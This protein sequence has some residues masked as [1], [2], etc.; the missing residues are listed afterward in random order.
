MRWKL[1]PLAAFPLF[2]A[3]LVV[4]AVALA[5]PVAA[6]P[7]RRPYLFKD[8]RGELAQ[9]RARGETEVVV[10]VASMPQRNARVAAAIERMGGRIGFRFDEVDYVRAWV[11]LEGAEQLAD[12]PDVHSIDISITNRPRSFGLA[13]G[14][15]DGTLP[16]LPGEGGPGDGGPGNAGAAAAGLT[17]V[18]SHGGRAEA[19]A[20]DTEA[21]DTVWPPRLTDR[22][23]A[24][25]Y[26]PLGDLRALDF[27]DANP[28]FDGRG[29]TIGQIDMF[30]DMLLPELQTA[31]ALDG[32]PVPKIEIYRNV[33]DPEIEDDGRW[34][35]MDDQVE[36]S[37]GAFV[38]RDS[39]YVAPR[40]GIFRI[41]MFDESRADSAG[42]Y[43]SQGLDLDVNRDGNPEGSSHFF[44]VLWDESAGD[45]WV[46][47]DQD[48]TLPKRPRSGSTTSAVNSGSSAPTTPTPRCANRWDSAS[49]STPNEIE[50]R[51][52]WASRGMARWSSA[53]R[54]AAGASAGDSTA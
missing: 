50:L 25:R 47:V 19:Q 37:D 41:A 16:L 28:T 32:R 27:L 8:A 3:A 54:S 22:P 53:R 52:T 44:A 18:A 26:S 43:G 42:V 31:Y 9:A 49:R 17:R 29:V 45:V 14:S 24:D 11:P 2:A 13:G 6:Q 35:Q 12:H 23:L 4:A 38:Y 34:I 5:T 10:V 40:D 15:P 33:L 7:E 39:T 30:P 21:A 36:A 1:I 48:R 20:A 46:D 51:S